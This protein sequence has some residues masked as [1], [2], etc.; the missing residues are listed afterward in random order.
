MTEIDPIEFGALRAEV[1]YLKNEVNKLGSDIEKLLEL[2][3]KSKGGFW[4]GM[5]IASALGGFAS[6][7]ISSFHTIR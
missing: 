7:F 4:T 5:A 6:W 3:N 2:A 1:A